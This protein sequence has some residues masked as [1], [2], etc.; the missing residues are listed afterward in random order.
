MGHGGGGDC[1][2]TGLSLAS[3]IAGRAVSCHLLSAEDPV[4]RGTVGTIL[5]RSLNTRSASEAA[6]SSLVPEMLL[7]RSLS[8]P[9]STALTASTSSSLHS[10][11]TVGT[12]LADSAVVGRRGVEGAQCPEE[13]SGRGHHLLEEIGLAA[14]LLLLLAAGTRHGS[15]DHWGSAAGL[16]FTAGFVLLCCTGAGRGRRGSKRR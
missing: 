10:G 4:D 13:L 11:H 15:T 8:L 6:G 7:S 9:P 12:A 5:I 3:G 14:Q 2:G 16:E 1:T